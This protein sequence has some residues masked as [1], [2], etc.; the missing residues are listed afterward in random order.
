VTSSA[1]V[2]ATIDEITAHGVPGRDLR[3]PAPALEN[4]VFP[5]PARKAAGL[6]EP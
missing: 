4:R 5:G 6:G 2:S 3:A 1:P